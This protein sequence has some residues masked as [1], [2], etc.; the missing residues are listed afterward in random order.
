[1]F[2]IM[3]KFAFCAE[4]ALFYPVHDS[5]TIG[6]TGVPYASY[7][8]EQGTSLGLSLLLYEKRS[9]TNPIPHQSFRFQI[10]GKSDFDQ[11]HELEFEGV[12]PWYHRN[13]Q[14]IFLLSFKD[15]PKTFYGIGGNT[16]QHEKKKYQRE[17]YIFTGNHLK[18]IS[19]QSAWGLAWD[20]SKY[21]NSGDLFNPNLVSLSSAVW[22]GKVQ[23]TT[24]GLGIAYL[25]NSRT[26]LIFPSRGHYYKQQVMFY[27]QKLGSDENFVTLQQD[28]QYY[29]PLDQHIFA[30]QIIM[31]N[32]FFQVPLNYLPE[33]GNSSMLRGYATGRF[34]DHHFLGVQTEYRSP[35]MIERFSAVAFLATGLS[36]YEPQN[37]TYHYFH[38]T[39]GLGLRIALDRIDRI[40]A[41]IDIGFSQEGSQLYLKFGEAF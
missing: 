40:N 5:L 19:A 4:Y 22:T 33:Q 21:Q 37:I 29:F 6:I 1:M 15:I 14:T 28:Y 10:N 3:G 26:P 13:F 24:S 34:L 11:L 32:T 7:T 16:S 27:H 8:S 17:Q 2:I 30:S 9:S 38:V 12:V 18:N 35:L 39:G 41:R 23:Y 31:N 36:F 20:F 25:Y